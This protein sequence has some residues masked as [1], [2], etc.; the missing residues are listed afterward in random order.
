VILARCTKQKRIY[1]RNTRNTILAI[2]LT[3]LPIL[4]AGADDSVYEDISETIF[5]E[6]LPVVLSA[7]RLVQPKAEAP[8]SITIIERDMIEASGITSLPEL[9][10][11]VPGFQVG[12]SHTSLLAPRP[13][14]VTYLGLSDEFSRRMQVLIDGR[15]V[16]NPIHGGVRWN[17]LPLNID[18]IERI[19]VVRGPNAA[20]Y[21]SNAVMG[22][23]NITTRSSLDPDNNYISVNASDIRY[24]KNTLKL[25]QQDHNLG[26]Q[27][28]FSRE[29]NNGFEMLADTINKDSLSFRSDYQPTD[30]DDISIHLGYSSNTQGLGNEPLGNFGDGI[31]EPFRDGS[32]TNHYQ[33][34]KLSHQLNDK[35]NL[36]I[37]LYQENYNFDDTYLADQGGF[38]FT[39]N[40]NDVESRRT[41][42][43]IQYL[44][45]YSP[46][47]RW[48]FG[49]EKRKDL[50]KGATWFSEAPHYT[51]R[52]NRLFATNEWKP[53]NKLFINTGLMFEHS[54]TA[55][56]GFSP[57]LAANY[58]INNNHTV[59]SSFSI[60]LRSPT[61]F[62]EFTS[63][64][65]SN[66]GNTGI[67]LYLYSPNNAD[68]K[69]EKL[70]ALDIGWLYEN[71]DKSLTLDSKLAYMQLSQF[72]TYPVDYNSTY[73]IND[74]R[75][76]VINNGD[77]DITTAEI[78]LRYKISSN[79][80]LY[81]TQAL[82]SASGS[83]PEEVLTSGYVMLNLEPATPASTTSLLLSH[84]FP[85]NL[86]L[87]IFY[88]HTSKM[89]W[90]GFA[91]N[92]IPVDEFDV[93]NLSLTKTFRLN[94]KDLQLKLV[95]QNL[96]GDYSDLTNKL[97]V[98]KRLLAI[99]TIEF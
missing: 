73:T 71:T 78:E 53:F 77:V 5:L 11:L 49:F 3:S 85:N 72:I 63:G 48:I 98:D 60:A 61:L 13:S 59:R 35:D 39:L 90:Y 38:D 32:S 33:Q 40:V 4:A 18:D 96:L 44:L 79:T 82:S 34:I 28:S 47:W 94:N 14:A 81:L 88:Y 6:E 69:P 30:D 57:K 75:I 83:A 50:V 22:V 74:P 52:L 66:I 56:S 68:L 86:N 42:V 46:N 55:D 92:N 87:G 84:Q 76:D 67:D 20:T 45:T 26:I 36:T 91:S 70:K 10:R 31:I 19:E 97:E 25:S 37:Q 16:Y 24:Q 12:H 54:N 89:L 27:L 21:G 15:V 23:I 99:A 43:E 51:N 80:R 58:R 93:L 64:K 2:A 29:I 8:A 41:D 62:E 65:I 1:Q 95:G 17:S 9:F 7:S